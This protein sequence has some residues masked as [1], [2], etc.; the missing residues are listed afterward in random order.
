M[1]IKTSMKICNNFENVYSAGCCDLQYI[2]RGF[3]P[4]YYNCGVHGWNC[5]LYID[6]KTDTIITTGYRNMRG[7]MI[8]Q[9]LIEK[10]NKKAAKIDVWSASAAEQREELRRQFFDEL[11]KINQ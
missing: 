1:K 9:E 10:Y 5:D 6:W 4:Q 2:F 8:P 7:K 11:E 3:E